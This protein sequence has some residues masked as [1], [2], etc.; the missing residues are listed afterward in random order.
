MKTIKFEGL[1]AYMILLCKG[2]YKNRDIIIKLR[3]LSSLFLGYDYDEKNLSIDELIANKLYNILVKSEQ[4]DFINFQKHMHNEFAKYWK[5]KNI[6]PIE[7]MINF[8]CSEI[9]CLNVS[10]TDTNGMELPK[11]IHADLLNNFFESDG[12]FDKELYDKVK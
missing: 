5:Y 2:H 1:E 8:Y 10:G 3:M 12:S 11:D 7:A 6:K 4:L 9:A